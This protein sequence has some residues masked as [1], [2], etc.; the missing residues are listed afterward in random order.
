M[1]RVA[2]SRFFSM[3]QRCWIVFLVVPV[4]V[5]LWG[6]LSVGFDRGTIMNN[7]NFLQAPAEEFNVD[8]ASSSKQLNEWRRTR[9][10][11]YWG[12]IDNSTGK[13]ML[14][15]NADAAGP[16]L[17]FAIVGFPK[18]GTTTLMANLAE[19]APMPPAI[20]VCTPTHNTVYYAY[21]N[22]VQQYGDKP[23]KGNKCPQYLESKDWTQEFSTYLPKTKLIAGIRHPIRWF[24]SFYNMQANHRPRE[25]L[26][27]Y[28]KTGTCNRGITCKTTGCPQKQLFCTQ[29]GRFQLALARLGKTNLTNTE[30]QLLAPNDA[31]GGR[32]LPNHHV[33]NTVLVYDSSQLRHDYFWK[34]LASFLEVP[35]IQNA[36]YQA[37]KLNRTSQS[38]NICDAKFDKLR[39]GMMPHA[40]DLYQWLDQYFVP[41]SLTR[42]DVDIANVTHFR[43]IIKGYAEDPCGRLARDA[44]TGDWNIPNSSSS[45]SL[46]QS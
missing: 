1:V 27:P 32:N 29:R 37:S 34:E 20:D 18:T 2:P 42:S 5:G 17:D 44:N 30:R 4:A 11:H 6:N 26:D 14:K 31:Y 39:K 13:D 25:K 9:R 40:Y 41:A 8:D 10:V 23:L 24:E 15:P 22:W 36:H 12:W 21:H 43:Q 33:V 28:E 35:E 19:Y 46:V 16:I 3:F 38:I 45:S 7:Q